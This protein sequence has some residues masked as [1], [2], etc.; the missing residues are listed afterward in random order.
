MPPIEKHLKTSLEAC[1]KDC[2][3]VHEWL[4][5][6]PAKKAERHDLTKI[7][8]NGSMIEQQYGRD[9]REEYIRHLHDDVK[10][11]FDHLKHDFEKQLA[12][13]LAYFGV[14]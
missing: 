2:R 12:D 8:E 7:F 5:A 14:R 11:K 9:A 1:G 6:D 13:T 3:A 4:D 10:A